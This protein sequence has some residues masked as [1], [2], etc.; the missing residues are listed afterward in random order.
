[1]ISIVGCVLTFKKI[2]NVFLLL[3]KKLVIAIED[4]W[5]VVGTISSKGNIANIGY[6]FHQI[7][8]L[9]AHVLWVVEH[10]L[11]S[12]D[13]ACVLSKDSNINTTLVVRKTKLKKKSY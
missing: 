13:P 2:L 6:H 1:L 10:I 11:C 8:K 12:I 4:D 5:V 9:R 3:F 7:K